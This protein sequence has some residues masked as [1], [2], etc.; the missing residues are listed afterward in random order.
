GSERSRRSVMQEAHDI[1]EDV[2][3]GEK[4]AKYLSIHAVHPFAAKL[5][6]VAALDDRKL[7]AQVGAPEELVDRRFQEEGLAEPES[8]RKTHCSVRNLRWDCVTRTILARVTQVELVQFRRRDRREQVAVDHVDL[9]RTLDSVCRCSIGRHIKSLVR[10]FGI[11]KVVRNSCR[12]RRGQ[13]PVEAAERCAIF[14]GVDD[15]QAFV[16]AKTVLV[17]VD[18]CQALTIGAGS[19]CRIVGTN[20]RS[21]YRTRS[22]DR[23]AQIVT[24]EIFED[25]LK[26]SEKECLIPHNGSTD[27]SPGLF[28]A[29]IRK[30]FSVR[31]VGRQPLQALERKAP[32][33]ELF[34]AVLGK[35]VAPPPRRA[36]ELGGGA[37][38]HDLEL[39]DGFHADV[40]GGSL[41]P[42]LLA[43][44]SV[45]VIAA[46]EG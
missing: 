25:L 1:A 18:Q 38:R 13:V 15:R 12:V 36:T 42:D 6:V 33:F 44:K 46:V 20:H 3:T 7:V 9:R 17:E 19:D 5:D 27:A 29:K 39:P 22:A 30:G 24:P 32:P 10:V 45:V 43:K 8:R 4:A 31:R 21:R 35:T 37:G 16:L 26:R 2:A 11:V 40:H 23:S 34:G 41:A 28:A 14:D